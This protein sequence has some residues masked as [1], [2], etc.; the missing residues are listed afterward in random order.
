MEPRDAPD[1]VELSTS[2]VRG[3]KGHL[4]SELRNF[5][6]VSLTLQC[7]CRTATSSCDTREGKMMD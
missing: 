1:V 2:S 7:L 6:D 5:S 4:S 3:G